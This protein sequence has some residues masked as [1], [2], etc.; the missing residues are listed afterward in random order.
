[1]LFFCV[2]WGGW[3]LIDDMFDCYFYCVIN[4]RD[5]WKYTTMYILITGIEH[6]HTSA[7]YSYRLHHWHKISCY[8]LHGKFS[9]SFALS[10]PAD[11]WFYWDCLVCFDS[12]FGECICLYTYNA[13]FPR[14]SFVW[15][16]VLGGEGGGG[17]GYHMTVR[18]VKR[19]IDD[20]LIMRSF[21]SSITTRGGIG[22]CWND[23]RRIHAYCGVLGNESRDGPSGR[24][25]MWTFWD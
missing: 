17:G 1:M 15:M 5:G 9:L 7:S 8:F 20:W 22:M 14:Y 12:K 23:S 24:S 10:I 4:F 2:F 16:C 6:L 11:L 19:T 21:A 13:I 25:R 18:G 3:V